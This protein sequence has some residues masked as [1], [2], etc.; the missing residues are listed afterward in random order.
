VS[1]HRHCRRFLPQFEDAARAL[2]SV[3]VGTLDAGVHRAAARALGVSRYPTVA[4]LAPAAD[5]V[6][7]RQLARTA[8]SW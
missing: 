2:G 3:A 8:R 4:V 7:A 6:R 1:A 5:G